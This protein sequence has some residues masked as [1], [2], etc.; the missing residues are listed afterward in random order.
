MRDPWNLLQGQHWQQLAHITHGTIVAMTATTMPMITPTSG[1]VSTSQHLPLSEP[2][3]ISPLI[4]QLLSL[5]KKPQWPVSGGHGVVV[6]VVVVVVM[7]AVI[8]VV[9]V[10][11]VP[12][13]TNVA[14]S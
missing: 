4:Q 3:Q 5:P 14:R 2:R 6:V 8:V 10:R 7:V 12:C 9:R 13:I 11:V 1:T